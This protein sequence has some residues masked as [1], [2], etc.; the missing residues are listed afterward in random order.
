[1]CYNCQ[2]SNNKVLKGC[3]QQYCTLVADVFVF[4][5]SKVMIHNQFSSAWELR[6][7]SFYLRAVISSFLWSQILKK[8]LSV[9]VSRLQMI[10]TKYLFY[11]T[12]S[13]SRLTDVD[14]ADGFVHQHHQQWN[15]TLHKCLIYRHWLLC[16]V[17][18]LLCGGLQLHP[19][20]L[21]LISAA[22]QFFLQAH[23]GGVHPLPLL[24]N[25]VL[26]LSGGHT[27]TKC[28]ELLHKWCKLHTNLKCAAS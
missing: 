21:S 20:L 19:P 28:E 6:N 5:G 17:V 25:L 11:P 4:Y 13:L 12:C 24:F 22:L 23:Y 2:F 1:M 8:N 26:G 16:C 14:D 10:S 15:L 3:F 7:M 18:Q 9:C 27:Q